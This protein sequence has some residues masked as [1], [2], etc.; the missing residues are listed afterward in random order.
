MPLP[1]NGGSDCVEAERGGRN[2]KWR[3]DRLHDARS[4]SPRAEL[5]FPCAVFLF[6]TECGFPVDAASRW[7]GGMTLS[8]DE[9]AGKWWFEIYL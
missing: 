1:A 7:A 4:K 6:I 2:A 3:I 9:L 5:F 8:C